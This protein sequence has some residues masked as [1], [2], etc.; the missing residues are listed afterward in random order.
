MSKKLF[1]QL[2]EQAG[3][4]VE[5][6]PGGRP[7]GPFAPDVVYPYHCLCDAPYRKI[8][9]GHG[10]HCTNHIQGEEGVAATNWT[11][12][13]QMLRELIAE[14]FE[15]CDDPECD[16]CLDNAPEDDE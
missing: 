5:Y 10:L 4:T 7:R 16:Y 2:A 1:F 11:E 12:A 8:F 15:D 9:K 13:V 14:G 3:I 6:T